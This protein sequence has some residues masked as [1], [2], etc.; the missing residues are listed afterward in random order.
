M[1]V[2]A[3]DGVQLNTPVDALI[4]APVGGVIKEKVF[5]C[6]ASTSVAVAW[7]VSSE[8][9]STDLLPIDARTG[10]SLTGVTVMEIF[11]G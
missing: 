4:V 9:F 3:A 1:K 5:V 7:N 10:V 2:P 6:P 8:P 11:A